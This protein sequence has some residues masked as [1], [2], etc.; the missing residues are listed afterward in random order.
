MKRTHYLTKARAA[1]D[2]HVD[3]AVGSLVALR[4][5]PEHEGQRYPVKRRQRLDQNVRK[6]GCLPQD[7]RQLRVNRSGRVGAVDLL[8]SALLASQQANVGKLAQ[9][10]RDRPWR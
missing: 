9:F 2:H 6:T 10:A 5:R 8:V 7:A 3:I 4:N 1:H